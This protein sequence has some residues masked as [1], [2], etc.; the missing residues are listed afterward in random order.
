M[1]W[2]VARGGKSCYH[3]AM[4]RIPGYV[5]ELKLL[6]K[7]ERVFITC[8]DEFIPG[9]GQYMLAAEQGAIQPTALIPTGR[10]KH[11]FVA[12]LPPREL[13]KPGTTLTLFGPLGNGFNLPGDVQRLAMIALGRT[14]SHLLP[15][16]REFNSLQ[17]SF[18]LFSD[19]LPAD[20]PPDVEVYPLQDFSESIGWADFFVVDMPITA[21]GT[22][23]AMF[24]QPLVKMSGLRGQVLVQSEMPCCGLGKCGVCAIKVKRSWKLICEDG[25]V[26]ELAGLLKGLR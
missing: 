9:P 21:L 15:L 7:E 11:G 16:M 8:P 23:D 1:E 26:F 14:N 3:A 2:V 5:A 18:T 25:P 20:L 22:L 24:S 4:R 13:W 19:V 6:S 12:A 10:W 17:S